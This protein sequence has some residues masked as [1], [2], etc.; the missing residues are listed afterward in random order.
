MSSGKTAVAN[1]NATPQS[2]KTSVGNAQNQVELVDVCKYC[3][4]S[5]SLQT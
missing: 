3:Q 1:R 2:G 5:I 4:V